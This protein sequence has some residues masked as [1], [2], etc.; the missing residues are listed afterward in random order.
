LQASPFGAGWFPSALSQVHVNPDGTALVAET[1]GDLTHYYRGWNL[2]T[3]LGH[4]SEKGFSGDGGPAARARFDE[5]SG[6]VVRPD[7]TLLIADTGNHRIRAITPDGIIQTL[8][9]TGE[10]GYS[11]DGGPA[12]EARFHR[13]MQLALDA[14]GNLYV[15][16]DRAGDV[17]TIRK[18]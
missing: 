3:Y 5:P 2:R 15:R 1:N 9:G 8:Y 18:I 7:G 17:Y 13:P 4:V 16:D 10:D 12:T 14:A 6:M 11:G